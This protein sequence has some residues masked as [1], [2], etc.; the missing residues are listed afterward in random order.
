MCTEFVNL[1]AICGQ[2]SWIGKLKSSSEKPLSGSE[3]IKRSDIEEKTVLEKLLENLDSASF[4]P[5]SYPLIVATHLLEQ[6]PPTDVDHRDHY[7]RHIYQLLQL[8]LEERER[9]QERDW[10]QQVKLHLYGIVKKTSEPDKDDEK[11]LNQQFILERNL[12]YFKLAFAFVMF[13]SGVILAST[14]FQEM[15]FFMMGAAVSLMAET[16]LDKSR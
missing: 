12:I 3:F 6:L 16:V 5:E 13:I 15:G 7:L 10:E 8:K 4:D 1:F 11:I 9:K 2:N 14:Q